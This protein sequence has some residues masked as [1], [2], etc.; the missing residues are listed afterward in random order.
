MRTLAFPLAYTGVEWLMSL[1]KGTN[2][3]GSA[4]YS[5]YD[6]LALLQIV[7]VFG[8]WGLAFLIGWTAATV[9]A[10][11]EA[12]FALRPVRRAVASLVA[13]LAATMLLGSLR[14]NFAP[15]SSPTIKA[16]TVTIDRDVFAATLQPPFD[17]LTFNRSDDATRAVVRPELEAGVA[18]LLARTETALECRGK[19]RRLAGDRRARSRRGPSAGGRPRRRAR[20]ANPCTHPDFARRVHPRAGAALLA[21]PVNPHR[22]Q[23]QSFVGL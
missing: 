1:F 9:N 11:W 8:M 23:R 10:V 7:S 2:T 16:A 19:A 21:R 14:L 17:W 22:R 4:V 3:T 6:S 15:P 13:V 18:Q 12:G 20:R 5:Q